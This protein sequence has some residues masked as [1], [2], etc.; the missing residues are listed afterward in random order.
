MNIAYVLA[1]SAELRDSR[2]ATL[3]TIDLMHTEGR[4]RQ[5]ETRDAFVDSLCC[6]SW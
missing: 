1:G 6:T 4:E 3:A 2:T 5:I